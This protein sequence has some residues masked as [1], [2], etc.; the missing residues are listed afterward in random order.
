MKHDDETDSHQDAK[1]QTI[2]KSNKI[3]KGRF[4]DV[5]GE[6]AFDHPNGAEKEQHAIRCDDCGKQIKG[7][8]RV[9]GIWPV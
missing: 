1:Y 4:E 7:I 8:F 5:S 6:I 9:D 2:E 3:E